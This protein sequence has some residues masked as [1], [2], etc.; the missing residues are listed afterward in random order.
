MEGRRRSKIFC[1]VGL[2]LAVRKHLRLRVATPALRGK[3]VMNW[4][5]RFTVAATSAEHRKR[6]GDIQRAAFC[7]KP[8]RPARTANPGR[9]DL[10]RVGIVDGARV[11][12]PQRLRRFKSACIFR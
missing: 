12:D 6:D 2:L 1:G 9:M 5:G 11:C 10:N 7:R 8:L 3:A 4:W